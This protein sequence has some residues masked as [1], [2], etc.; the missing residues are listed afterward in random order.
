MSTPLQPVFPNLLIAGD[1]WTVMMPSGGYGGGGWTAVLTFG[2]GTVKLSA[3]ATLSGENFAWLIP[4]AQTAPLVSSG[5]TPYLFTITVSDGT[6]RYTVDTGR[7][8]VIP[9]ITQVA[10]VT[11]NKTNLQLMLEACDKAL[12]SLFGQK[13]SMV[14]FAGQMYQFW[15]LDKLFKVRQSLASQ[16]RDEQDALRG[17]TRHRMCISTFVEYPAN[18]A[19]G[20]P[21]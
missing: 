16:V 3:T 21:F 8:D 10:N 17:A 9:D 13:T 11:G 15:E 2:A 4:G 18:A 14:Q 1:T 5:T 12:I 20:L 7:V 6:N 19:Y